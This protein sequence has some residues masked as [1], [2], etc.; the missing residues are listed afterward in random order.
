MLLSLPQQSDTCSWTTCTNFREL[1][2]QHARDCRSG[3]G[4]HTSSREAALSWL[5]NLCIVTADV[6]TLLPQC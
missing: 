3:D 1:L 6:Q 4:L 2:A 5:R